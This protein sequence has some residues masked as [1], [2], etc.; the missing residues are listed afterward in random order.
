MDLTALV[1]QITRQVVAA[2]ASPQ[3]LVTPGRVWVIYTEDT[4][5]FSEA[6]AT[7]AGSGV[8]VTVA[9]PRWAQGVI[10]AETKGATFRYEPALKPCDVA[11]ADLVIVPSIPRALANQLLAKDSEAFAAKVI[12]RAIAQ[13]KRVVA[14][15]GLNDKLAT[16][17]LVA[18]SP[19]DFLGQAAGAPQGSMKV[20]DLVAMG[21][22]RLGTQG[23][24]PADLQLARMID[25]TLLKADATDSEIKKLCQ[26]AAKCHFASVCVNPTNVPQAAKLLAGTDVKVCTVIGFPLGATPREV[27][28]FETKK[29]IADGAQEIDMVI[30]IGALKSKDYTL[31]EQDIRAVVEACPPGII[32]KVILET[33]L[34][35]D[36]EKVTACALAKSAGAN[37]VKTSTGFSTGGATIYDV[38]LMR[39]TV[40]PELGVKASGGVRDRATAVAMVRAGAT[41]IGA[42]ASVAI[43]SGA[44]SSGSGY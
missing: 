41:R 9:M 5:D 6:V 16:L 26:E 27:K 20:A 15:S 29:A 21:V 43:V 40:G 7:L 23:M 42:S 36:D 35:N 30:N 31:V 10:K 24:A 33:S 12:K 3:G 14:F 2:S 38:T 19:K 8:E 22:A 17:G 44:K 32:H 11:D 25:H 37:F 28:A 1:D 34:L 4:R 13:N 18:G 39:A